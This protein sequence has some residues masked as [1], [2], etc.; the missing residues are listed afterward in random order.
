MNYS[1]KV[2]LFMMSICSIEI[3]YGYNSARVKKLKQAASS[4]NST[5]VSNFA[6]AD[7]RGVKLPQGLDLHGFYMPGVVFLP[8]DPN[9]TN[10]QT[11]MVCVNQPADLTGVNFAKANISN[12]SFDAAILVGADLT[13]AD[14]TATSAIGANL[15]DAKV[16]GLQSQDATFCNSTMPDGK[17]CDANLKTWT[18]QGTTILCN[19]GS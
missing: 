2:F 7:F 11:P 4:P 18:G 5:T 3:S 8:C 17:I 19:C 10:K 13:N 14:M 1:I 16:A 12:A 15:K 9:D 6:G